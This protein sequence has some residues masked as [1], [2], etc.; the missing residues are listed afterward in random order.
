MKGLQR[1]PSRPESGLYA[2]GH[3]FC[4][5]FAEDMGPLYRL[6]FLLTG[7]QELAEQC[8]AS[9]LKDCLDAKH[10]FREWA[11]SW[12]KR[13]VVQNAIRILHSCPDRP[14]SSSPA[15]F[16]LDGE[17]ANAAETY[18]LIGNVLELDNFIRT[19]FVVTMLEH[20]TVHECS[21]LLGCSRRAV[22]EART[23]ALE[24]IAAS[25]RSD[26]FGEVRS[27]KHSFFAAWSGFSLP[28][29]ND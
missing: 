17:E 1:P 5:V 6:S 7:N 3:D 25:T 24:Q 21:L 18:S 2:I 22:V 4:K 29:G 19:V 26:S 16:F 27:A 14:H 11:G 20:Y 23:T 15:T 9:A 13:T 8:F 28:G 12:A 10:V